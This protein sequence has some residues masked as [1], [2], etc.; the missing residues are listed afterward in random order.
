MNIKAIFSVL[1][2]GMFIGLAGLLQ[3]GEARSLPNS[4]TVA[5]ERMT[6]EVK[7]ADRH[8]WRRQHRRHRGWSHHLHPGW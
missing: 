8:R 2:V 5:A 3:G 4:N 6:T 1:V 7:G